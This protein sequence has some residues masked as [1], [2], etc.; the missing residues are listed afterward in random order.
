MSDLLYLYGFVPEDA[1]PP[2]EG[3][4]GIAAREVETLPL[5]GFGALV[6]RVPAADYA[7]AVVEA[8][9][10]D[11]TWVGDQGALHERVVTW[12]V[13]HGHIVPVRLLTLYSGEEALRREAAA[14]AS[15]VRERLEATRG[16]REW[17]LKVAYQATVLREH[18][19]SLS[20]EVAALDREL[21]AADP[22]RRYLLE[23]KR[24]RRV[25]EETGRTARRLARE[26]LDAARDHA[27][28]VR[29]IQPPRAAA[30]IPVVLAAA[31]LVR[32]EEEDR[33]R[34]ALGERSRDLAEVGMK[35]ELTGPWAPYRFLEAAADAPVEEG[36]A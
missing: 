16:L 15:G 20:D 34:K 22:G 36:G 19:G 23:R 1:P 14:Q 7:P 12:Y 33:L 13:D 32:R 21:A 35:L 28:D 6:S 30:E 17:D 26:A 31:L 4:T 27:V 18:L 10:R 24:D 11:L 3:L 25:K 29:E 2:P 8:S 9:M 5:D